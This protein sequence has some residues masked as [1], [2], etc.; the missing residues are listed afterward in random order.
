MERPITSGE[1]MSTRGS[2][3]LACEA[4]FFVSVM[5][6]GCSVR[7]H[8]PRSM[9]QPSEVFLLSR[10]H[11]AELAALR[12][13][14]AAAKIATAKK[15]AELIEVRAG[16]AQAR[17]ESATGRQALL[18]LRQTAESRETEIVRLKAERDQW[19]QAK[20]D[21]SVNE[22]KSM[23]AALTQELTEVRREVALNRST[24]PDSAGKSGKQ[25]S[26][27]SQDRSMLFAPALPAASVR[28]EPE[29]AGQAASGIVPADLILRDH[30]KVR[31][32]PGETL[33]SLA[34]RHHTTVATLQSLNGLTS[35]K[36]VIG[37]LL[38]VPGILP[39]QEAR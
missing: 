26:Q 25:S 4:I 29:H 18:D 24:A 11:E 39:L 37:Q 28:Q 10:D 38:W 21:Q 19:L 16:L 6:G 15:E 20:S 13:E 34:R 7:Q 8:E 30:T 31:V 35:E 3:I 5:L 9:A 23:V 1:E 12:A 17:Q 22:L 36:V 27:R 33:S 2:L 14:L 32:Q